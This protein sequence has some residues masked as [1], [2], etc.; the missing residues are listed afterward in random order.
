[1]SGTPTHTAGARTAG[2]GAFGGARW[3]Q[4]PERESRP[5]WASLGWGLSVPL[6]AVW[7]LPQTLVGLMLV[8]MLLPRG[9]PV[10]VYRFG[11]FFFLVVPRGLAKARGISLG[12][13]VLADD[14]AIL[15]HEF[16]HLFS[17]LWLGWVYLPVYGLEYLLMGHAGSWH[18]RLTCRLTERV[19]WR[20]RCLWAWKRRARPGELS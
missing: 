11:P 1:M 14:P 13:V 19:A 17:G 2:A 12:L 15:R 16:C 5:G 8:A 18:E 10:G 6:L 9:W 7:T 20:W 4:D 3:Q